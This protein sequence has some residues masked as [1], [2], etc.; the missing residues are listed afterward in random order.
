MV[1][2]LCIVKKE[3]YSKNRKWSLDSINIQYAV[4]MFICV[5]KAYLIAVIFIFKTYSLFS[6][7]GMDLHYK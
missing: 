7:Y 3:V 4:L 6:I 5:R 1:S 2:I